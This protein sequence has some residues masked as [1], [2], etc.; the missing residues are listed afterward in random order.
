MADYKVLTTEGAGPAFGEDKEWGPL[1]PYRFHLE[2]VEGPVTWNRKPGSP[3]PKPGETI[4]G[5]LSDN[6][7]WGKKFKKAA[8]GGFGGGG[9]SPETQKRVTRL[10]CHKSA[11]QLVSVAASLGLLESVKD[12]QTLFAAVKGMADKLEGDLP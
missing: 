9:M 5:E 8:G 3:G 7:Q 4:S 6:G 2:G 10:A 12:S 1:I 11:V